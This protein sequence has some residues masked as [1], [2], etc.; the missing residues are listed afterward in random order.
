MRP[1]IHT[2]NLPTVACLQRLKLVCHLAV[3][4]A[5][6]PISSP[7]LAVQ[8]QAPDAAVRISE[9]NGVTVIETPEATYTIAE[10]PTEVE[11]LEESDD[12]STRTT[13]KSTLTLG[14]ALSDLDVKTILERYYSHYS[15]D[16]KSIVIRSFKVGSAPI[17]YTWCSFKTMFGCHN[18]QALAGVKVDFE[19]NGRNRSGGYS[20]FERRSWMVRKLPPPTGAEALKPRNELAK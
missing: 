10:R 15:F 11:L 5:L 19:V 12:R 1:T 7:L 9:F 17:F 8:I 6:L 20:G 16:P 3:L 18:W 13:L 14:D 2:I 4:F